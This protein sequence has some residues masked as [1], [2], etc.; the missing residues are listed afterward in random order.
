M[1]AAHVLAAQ[2]EEGLLAFVDAFLGEA[3][4]EIFKQLNV[5]ADK[6]RIHER[7]FVFLIEPCLLDAFGD[8]AAGVAD[9]EAH[10]PEEI[11]DVLHEV[12]QR[13]RQLVGCARQEEKDVDV[14][15]WVEQAAAV[16]AGG[17]E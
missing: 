7:G 12:L 10:V 11:E 2:F 17:D 3:G 6:A 15:A 14:R 9:L 8:R 5:A 1:T 16:A 4:L 13:L